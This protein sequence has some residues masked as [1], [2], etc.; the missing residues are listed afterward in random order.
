MRESDVDAVVRVLSLAR[1]A[2]FAQK[3]ER[4]S[5]VDDGKR[6]SR[7]LSA[8]SRVLRPVAR[9]TYIP[10]IQMQTS[11]MIWIKF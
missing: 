11:V 9:G 10:Q 1:F 3:V 6:V 5:F 4:P 7:D 8:Q 2:Y